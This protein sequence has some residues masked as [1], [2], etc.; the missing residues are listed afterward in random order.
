MKAGQILFKYR[1]YTPI[2]FLVLMFLYSNPIIFTF[3]PGLFLVVLG[4]FI[5]IWANSWA[6]SETRT[7]GSVG[8]TFLIISGPYAY[9][10]NPLYLGNILI[11][12]GLS[13]ISNAL[14]P[15][16]QIFGFILFFIQYSL[17]VKEEEKYLKEKFGQAY[18]DYSK[19][20]PAFIPR[21]K[22]FKNENI[23]QPE[24]SWKKGLESERRSIQAILSVIV[25]L[26]LIW[27][28]RRV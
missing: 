12:L 28:I 14:M 27:V 25:I 3:L 2:P 7:T 1:S 5:R 10:R 16:L 26:L 8:G 24:F 21:L 22:K 18:T 11:Y 17:I 13:I 15:Y 4:E 23:V 6:G 9:V 20:V 19:N